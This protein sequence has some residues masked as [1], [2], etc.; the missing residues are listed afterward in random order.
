MTTFLRSSLLQHRSTPRRSRW[1]P[2][3]LS[4]SLLLSILLVGVPEPGLGQLPD[5]TADLILRNGRVLDGAGNPW[6][7]ADVAIRGD[8]IVAVGRLQGWEASE[9]L[10]V[11]GFYVSPGFIDVHSHAG[12]GLASP[13]R[14][15]AFPLLAQGVTTA[16]INPDGGGSVDLA[17]QRG[18]L[19]E[20]GLGVNV[21]L[22]VPHGSIRSEVL[23]SEDRLATPAEMERMREMVR[24]GM[25]EGAFGLS[26]G[27]FYAPG[28][29]ADTG[30][31]VELSRVAAG[32]G[33]IY[34]S[35]I[36]DESDYTIGLVAAVDEVIT[37]AREAQIRGIVTHVKALGPR[38]WGYSGAVIQRIEQARAEG[39]EVFADQY[40]YDAS[41]TS[42]S[43]ALLPRWAQEGGTARLR[44]RFQDRET[45]TLI[46]AEMWDNLDRRGGADRIQFR[47]HTEDRS[48][49]GRTL[50]AVAVSRALDPIQASIGLLQEGG[51]SIVS[52]NMLEDDIVA[53]MR[54][55]WTMTSSD[56]EFPT[57]G[58]GVPH[59]RAYGAFARK[60]RKYVVEDAVVTL[61]EAVRSMT[62][63]PALVH[64]MEGRGL[65][66][67]GKVA[68]IAVFNLAAV[69][70]VGTFTD[71]HHYSEGMVHV[72]VNGRLALRGGEF[73]DERTGRVL[74]LGEP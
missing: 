23:G 14:S 32:F 61:E 56:G 24:R 17:E 16:I 36:R 69:R 67:P 3:A 18:R 71:P 58:D 53:L 46:E 44:E 55:S 20:H 35:H 22:L 28:S 2:A 10:D 41:A 27:P 47:F 8:R 33:G 59:P 26:S 65:L 4:L 52:F 37:I 9:E 19:L 30:E 39:V 38:V 1:R 25:E 48:I 21:A 64:R 13:D 42:L 62:S 43:A 63:L 72:L 7:L 31:L 73:T 29:Y 60:L 6:V 5:G 40:A 74:R 15:H 51:P 54:R 57:F 12:G 66:A 11:T 70:D 49:E 50:E 45:R 68:D 34:T